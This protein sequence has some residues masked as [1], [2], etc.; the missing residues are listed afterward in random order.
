MKTKWIIFTM[1]ATLIFSVVASVQAASANYHGLTTIYYN[2]RIIDQGNTH[3][4]GGFS[5]DTSPSRSMDQLGLTYWQTHCSCN[6]NIVYESIFSYDSSYSWMMQKDV[7]SF[8][9]GM[10]RTKTNCGGQQLRGHDYVQ[11]W[12]QDSGYAGAGDELNTSAKLPYP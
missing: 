5:M 11:Y 12:W 9:D 2:N 8:S 7:T 10:A 6:Y 4:N 1:C 3:W